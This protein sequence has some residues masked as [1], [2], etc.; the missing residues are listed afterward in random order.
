MKGYTDT[1][2]TN[3]FTLD[4]SFL[5]QGENTIYIDIDVGTRREWCVTCDWGN[6]RLDNKPAPSNGVTIDC[7]ITDY[8]EDTNSNS[9]FDNLVVRIGA[10]AIESGT[11][12][13]NAAISTS[14]GVEICRAVKSKY[15][16]ANTRG[17]FELKFDGKKIYS[18]NV[19]GPD[20]ISD[21]Y[22]YKG[23]VIYGNGD[24]VV[25]LEQVHINPPSLRRVELFK[26]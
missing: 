21:L 20:I 9:K 7:S 26:D 17:E 18:R 13:L 1:W 2:T 12:Y 5:V 4:P 15:L 22:V 16:T 25:R 19:A 8:G 23:S 6:I 14:N 3:T 24:I 10:T 11:Y